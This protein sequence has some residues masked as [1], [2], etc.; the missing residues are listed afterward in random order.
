MYLQSVY[1]VV[2]MLT[3]LHNSRSMPPQ[4]ILKLIKC[5]LKLKNYKKYKIKIMTFKQIEETSLKR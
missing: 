4:A 3:V 5:S 2:P 1:T